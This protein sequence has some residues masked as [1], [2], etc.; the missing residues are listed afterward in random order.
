[1]WIILIESYLVIL[2]VSHVGFELQNYLY[3]ECCVSVKY[4]LSVQYLKMHIKS[5]FK[6]F[7]TDKN[8]FLQTVLLTSLLPPTLQAATRTLYVCPGINSWH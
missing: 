5:S 1:M 6:R 3:S 4:Y 7:N 8:V 2:V